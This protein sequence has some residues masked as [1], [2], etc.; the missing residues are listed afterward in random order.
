V[1][2]QVCTRCIL[3]SHVPHVTFNEHGVCNLCQEHAANPDPAAPLDQD[4]G[5]KSFMGQFTTRT[6]SAGRKYDCL[7]LFSGGK[8]STAMLYHLKKKLGLNVL[9]FTLDN[10]MLSPQAHDNIERV[11][12]HLGVDHVYHKPDWD[13]MAHLFRH[14]VME[15]DRTAKGRRNAF[16]VG[17]VCWPCFVMVCLFSIKTAI[18][19]DIR[20]IIVG[21]T[22]G[23]MRQKDDRLKAKYHGVADIYFSMMRPLLSQLR[24]SYRARARL[25]LWE[26]ARSLRV[27]IV[28]LYEYFHYDEDEAFRIAEQ[29][30]N[31]VRPGDTDSCSTNCLVNALGIAIHRARYGVSP[32]LVPIA[33]DVRT[34]LVSRQDALEAVSAPVDAD[35]VHRMA[36]KLDVPADEYLA[37]LEQVHN[38]V[39]NKQA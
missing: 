10:W 14:G 26:M 3:N 8:D 24:G 1:S 28:P 20:R 17:H 4:K 37:G 35:Q 9:A 25:S 22:P 15:S 18:A 19:H 6:A 16:M 31:W 36:T 21:T 38:T 39:L 5:L 12:K 32:Y 27:R 30:C 29:E 7:C 33:Y 34:G 13:L 23:Q 11:T 2:H